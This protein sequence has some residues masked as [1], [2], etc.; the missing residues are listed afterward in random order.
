MHIDIYMGKT[1]NGGSEGEGVVKEIVSRKLSVKVGWT[2]EMNGK[3]KSN[4]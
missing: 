1:T 3:G 4:E 2:H